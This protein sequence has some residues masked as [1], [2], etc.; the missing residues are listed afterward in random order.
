MQFEADKINLSF[1][2]NICFYPV[3]LKKTKLF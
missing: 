3:L 2:Q 1:F